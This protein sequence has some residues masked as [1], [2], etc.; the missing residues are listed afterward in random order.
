[1]VELTVS[2]PLEAVNVVKRHRKKQEY[3]N[4][5]E[6]KLLRKTFRKH[7]YLSKEDCKALALRL[8]TSTSK[9]R[10]WFAFQ[11]YNIRHQKGEV[12]GNQ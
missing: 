1:M 10:R 6:W 4:A 7:P 3:F 2:I 12:K 11:R 9:I 8:Q 5:N